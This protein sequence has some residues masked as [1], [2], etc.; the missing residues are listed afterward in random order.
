MYIYPQSKLLHKHISMYGGS[1]N[2][3][4]FMICLLFDCDF[5]LTFE[6]RL[7]LIVRAHCTFKFFGSFN[8]KFCRFTVM[9]V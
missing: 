5:N 1:I 4:L 2:V 7:I 8:F 9:T 3:L 6:F